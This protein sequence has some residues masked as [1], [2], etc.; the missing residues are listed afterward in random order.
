MTIT[1]TLTVAD[2]TAAIQAWVASTAG[3]SASVAHQMNATV[4]PVM[5]GNGGVEVQLNF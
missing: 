1:M 3:G 5:Q 2:L 4:P